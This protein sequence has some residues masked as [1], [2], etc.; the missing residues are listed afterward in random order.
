MFVINAKDE[1]ELVKKVNSYNKPIFATQPIQK[2]D[3]SW[4]A[5]V[6]SDKKDKV[7]LPTKRMMYFLQHNTK[8]SDIDLADLNFQEAKQLIK[9]IK[10]KDGK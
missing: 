6:Y 9:E 10:E 4:V 2:N 3:D 1:Y 7:D 5:F 8:L